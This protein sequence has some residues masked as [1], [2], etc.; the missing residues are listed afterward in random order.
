MCGPM[1]QEVQCSCPANLTNRPR[2]RVPKLSPTFSERQRKLNIRIR[3]VE[4]FYN[5]E[6]LIESEEVNEVEIEDCEFDV[7]EFVLSD[8]ED[9]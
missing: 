9:G 2:K 1:I 3:T 5:D 7:L 4:T 6:G 8:R